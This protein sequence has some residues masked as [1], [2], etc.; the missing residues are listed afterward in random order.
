MVYV[1][2]FEE[3]GYARDVTPRYARQYAAKVAKIQGGAGARN[4]R[5]AWWELVVA[6]VRRPY[7]LV[8]APSCPV[9]P[10]SHIGLSTAT[11]SKTPSW[12]WRNCMRGCPRR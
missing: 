11:T 3:D 7:R 12:T 9:S 2:A 4:G 8:R 1:L 10:L 6:G 5:A